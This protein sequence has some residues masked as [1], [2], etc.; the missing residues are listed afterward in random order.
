MR[1]FLLFLFMISIT[2]LCAIEL[3][4]PERPI[5]PVGQQSIHYVTEIGC[6][7]A[8]K[9]LVRDGA[10]LSAKN[11]FGFTPLEVALI[12]GHFEIAWFLAKKM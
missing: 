5:V 1:K 12:Y 2:Y 3:R 10:D 7:R 9:S 8:V 11:K 6:F 4:G